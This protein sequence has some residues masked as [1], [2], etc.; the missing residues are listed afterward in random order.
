[1]NRP[2][3]T[4]V[5][6]VPAGVSQHRSRRNESSCGP[7]RAAHGRRPTAG[8]DHAVALLHNESLT[9]RTTTVVGSRRQCERLALNARDLRPE[10]IVT[11]PLTRTVQTAALSFAPQLAAG[12]PLV[13]LEA[14][15][16][17]VN[18]LCDA[19]ASAPPPR[20]RMAAPHRA[21]HPRVRWP[22][23]GS[24]G[25]RCPFARSMPRTTPRRRPLSTIVPEMAAD[26]VTLDTSAGCSH[27]HDEVRDRRRAPAEAS[28]QSTPSR[29][30]RERPSHARVAAPRPHAR[31]TAACTRHGHTHAPQPHARAR[32][33]L[34][35]VG[36]VR[37]SARQPAGLSRAPRVSRLAQPCGARACCICVAR[38]AARA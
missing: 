2:S 26:G 37:E 10:V 7:R 36:I 35:V 23:D 15:R 22:E 11:S 33:S 12:V 1:L 29:A 21:A 19:C 13:A 6:I 9:T 14:V 27:D 16:E 28:H 38:C 18:Y 32:G 24:T 34:A 20:P 3:P 5:Q 17:T 8:T 30:S 25:P 4:A 31:A